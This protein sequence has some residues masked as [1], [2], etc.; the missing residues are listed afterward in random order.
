MII[1]APVK[2]QELLFGVKCLLPVMPD[3]IRYPDPLRTLDSGV[4]QSDELDINIRALKL[5][6]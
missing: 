3:S 6:L 5:E 2:N 4:R 1:R